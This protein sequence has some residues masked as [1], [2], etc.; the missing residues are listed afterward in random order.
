[1]SELT[2]SPAC[3]SE[4]QGEAEEEQEREQEQ[5]QEQ[6]GTAPHYPM[7]PSR[8][9]TWSRGV[10]SVTLVVLPVTLPRLVVSV[11]LPR[12]V[13]CSPVRCLSSSPYSVT[14]AAPFLGR[15]ERDA[16]ARALGGELA[17]Q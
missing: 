15:V 1:M 4:E 14:S 9:P 6:R 17:H 2:E 10:K 3:E 11:T 13:V 5:E 8:S 16:D 12:F 7:S